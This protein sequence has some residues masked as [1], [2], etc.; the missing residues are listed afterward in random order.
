MARSRSMASGRANCSPTKPATKRPPRISPRA[1][2]RRST[3]S[4]SRH[5]GAS[6]SRASRSRKTTPQRS[7]N[8]LANASC[9]AG[10]SRERVTQQRPPSRGVPGTRA[11]APA[12]AAA[13]LRIDQRA[14]ILEAVGGHETG[15]HQFP[16]RVFDFARQPAGGARQIGEERRAALPQLGQNLACGVRER[17]LDA[18]GFVARRRQQ[19][20]GVFA[21]ENR[22]GR[23]ARGPNA[24]RLRRARRPDAARAGPTSLRP[25]GR[26]GRAGRANSARCGAAGFP[27]PRRRRRS[28]SPAAGG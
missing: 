20:V 11:A 15:G 14:Q 28:R 17:I 19:P 4:R 27:I 8:W 1:S 9:D 18:G 13:A 5:G 26:A 21:Q 22:E 2:M 7:S 25:T 16:E 24:A 12:F 23:N 10:G 3:T 6:V